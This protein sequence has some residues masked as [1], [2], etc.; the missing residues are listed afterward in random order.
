MKVQTE[1]ELAYE[2]KF[3]FY[4]ATPPLNILIALY[5]WKTTGH[6]ITYWRKS[7]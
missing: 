7:D 4:T 2:G 1:K 3:G 6:P 5:N